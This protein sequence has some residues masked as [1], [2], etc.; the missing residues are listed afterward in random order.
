MGGNECD[1]GNG[2]LAV[3]HDYNLNQQYLIYNERSLLKIRSGR[4]MKLS[5]MSGECLALIDV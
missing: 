4:Q 5:T 2:T 1:V 3:I